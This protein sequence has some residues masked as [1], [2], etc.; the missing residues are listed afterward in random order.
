MFSF[1]KILAGCSQPPL[2]NQS[3]FGIWRSLR[4]SRRLRDTP[5]SSTVAT[6]PEE[7]FQ[8]KVGTEMLVTGSDDRTMKLWDTRVRGKVLDYQDQY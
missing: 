2:T 6:P 3:R 4:E 7:V 1:H 8:I 5:V